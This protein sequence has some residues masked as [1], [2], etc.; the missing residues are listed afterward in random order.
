[1]LRNI[2][3]YEIIKDFRHWD[4]L[5]KLPKAQT[6]PALLIKCHTEHQKNLSTLL[7]HV[8]RKLTPTAS[9]N[10]LHVLG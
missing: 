7:M 1:M 4:S 9:G 10:S 2:T 3:L 5:L 8:R 6:E